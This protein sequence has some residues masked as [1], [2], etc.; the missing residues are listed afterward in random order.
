MGHDD[1]IDFRHE[2]SN[3]LLGGRQD[4]N[5]SDLQKRNKTKTNFARSNK[6]DRGERLTA[7]AHLHLHLPEFSARLP[8]AF[9]HEAQRKG[10][11][12][13]H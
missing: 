2:Q 13:L 9:S 8:R 11:R 12:W 6:Q 1:Q 3:E 5:G 4:G 7:I 10:L